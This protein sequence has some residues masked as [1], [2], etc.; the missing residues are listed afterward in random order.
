VVMAME[1][2][3]QFSIQ[4]GSLPA[5]PLDA[6]SSSSTTQGTT[7]WGIGRGDV[8]H[9]NF[10]LDGDYTAFIE[11]LREKFAD[12]TEQAAK[13]AEDP[14]TWHTRHPLLPKQQFPA[15]PARWMHIKLIVETSNITLAVRDD[16]VY[17]IGFKNQMGHWYEFGFELE[18]MNSGHMIEGSK[19]LQCDVLYRD[20]V[21]DYNPM[22]EEELATAVKNKDQKRKGFIRKIVEDAQ[23]GGSNKE[24]VRNRLLQLEL[25]RELVKDAVRRLSQYQGEGKR[26]PLERD[27][28]DGL[29]RLIVMV[30]ESARMFPYF[31]TVGDAW[32]REGSSCRI[33]QG[34]V[35][36]LW[37]WKRMSRMLL[38]N[39]KP[40]KYL[41]EIKITNEQDALRVVCLVLNSAPGPADGAGGHGQ[42]P[43]TQ[44][45]PAAGSSKQETLPEQSSF[46][47][48]SQPRAQQQSARQHPRTSADSHR[49]RKLAEVFHV[50]ANFHVV[51]T[52]IVFDGKRGQVI[53]SQDQGQGS[54][55]SMDDSQSEPQDLV[56]TGPY[57]AISADGS[58]VLQVDDTGAN[59]STGFK[60]SNVG[61]A[62]FWDGYAEYKGCNQVLTQNITMAPGRNVEVTYGVLTNAVE[63]YVMVRLFNDKIPSW[64][65][66]NPAMVYGKIT[67]H[68]EGMDADSVLFSREPE[69]KV[70]VQYGAVP[71]LPLARSVVAVP[72]NSKMMITLDLHA[73]V[74]GTE[75]TISF[76]R[77]SEIHIHDGYIGMGLSDHAMVQVQIDHDFI[78]VGFPDLLNPVFLPNL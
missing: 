34:E 10:N 67:A 53:Y 41:Q 46:S 51:G 26:F 21:L 66:A 3:P 33:A 43:Q 75:D 77:A 52:I 22:S 14:S 12:N 45:T 13:L 39:E 8:V 65:R 25:G 16:T 71:V 5:I 44:D 61:A 30:C 32:P 37:N 38:R 17:L 2:D 23:M 27:I 74:F 62:M 35:D 18:G 9:V 54:G 11:E 73:G 60:S 15:R 36:Y 78:G 20:L 72:F 69:E 57:K 64:T 42:P 31:R 70:E 24:E 76:Q 29:A 7:S 28:R 55:A 47:E 19:F 63:A 1:Q 68:L 48:P 4:F 49:G 40:D 6:S 59:A 50:R 56:L 58:F